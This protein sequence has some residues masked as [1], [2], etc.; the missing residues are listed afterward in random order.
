MG[1][2]NAPAQFQRLMDL[3]LA[4]L[5]FETCLVYLDDII[6]FSKTF[7]QHLQ[8]LGAIFDRLV[9]ANLLLSAP[10]CSLFQPEVRFLG[11]VVGRSGIATDP[12]KIDAVL[13]WPP[14]TN[15]QEVRS[16]IGLTGYYRRFIAGYAD[17]ARPL[18]ML[19]EKGQPFVWNAEQH[20]AFAELKRRLVSAPIL[21]SPRDEGRYV[22]DSDASL[23]GLGTV[24]QQEQDGDLKVI[25]YGSRL[26]TKAERNYTTTKRE[27]LA[28]IFGFKQFRQFFLGRRF[29]FRF[30]H[31]AITYLRQTPEIMGQAARWLEFIEEY[32]FD[33]VHRAGAAHGN[34]DA[35]SRKPVTD[36]DRDSGC[37]A[38][39]TS[40]QPPQT[41]AISRRCAS[42]QLRTSP[43]QSP[44]NVG[45]DINHSSH[46][47]VQTR[48]TSDDR[49]LAAVSQHQTAPS[50]SIPST[51][52]QQS[53]AAASPCGPTTSAD[54]LPSVSRIASIDRRCMA[55]KVATRQQT[56]VSDTRQLPAARNSDETILL[57]MDVEQ[58]TPAAD[59]F[60]SAAHIS[61]EQRKDPHLL[62]LIAAL[63]S[64][65]KRPHWSEIQSTSEETRALWAQFDSLQ[66]SQD[67]VL[68]RA[69]YQPSGEILH[70]Q[71]VMPTS[72]RQ[73]FMANLHEENAG[74]VHLGVGKTVDHVRCRA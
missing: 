7:E 44:L 4:G 2:A 69:F 11:H 72:L 27:L 42:R 30:D 20:R 46:Q 35:L 37:Q 51:T 61:A 74:T 6:C 39:A 68:R 65:G 24:L 71:T 29:L 56:A 28:V 53:L 55:T 47:P 5:N 36:T 13:N 54:D 67:G 58:R 16:F 10:K 15:L 9:A 34:C 45:V 22:L 60:L 19:T 23:Y 14:P 40:D 70:F 73:P 18:H 43:E 31:S 64:T 52:G 41:A 59:T 8:R 32:D 38:G 25:G 62:P 48:P 26:L 21:A 33:I 57:P 1:L 50:S 17:I 3:V 12:S 66:L 49:T 63:E